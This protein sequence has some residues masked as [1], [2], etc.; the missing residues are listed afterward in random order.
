MI[1]VNVGR[2]CNYYR[3]LASTRIHLA[4][5]ILIII[6]GV[7]LYLYTERNERILLENGSDS[8]I[9]HR[10]RMNEKSY[11]SADRQEGVFR[12]ACTEV[13]VCAN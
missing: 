9:D 12:P 5:Y 1:L 10:P 2:I 11:R 13:D 7:R 6:S 4:Q 8:A 3:G